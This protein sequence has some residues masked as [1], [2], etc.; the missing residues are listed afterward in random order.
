MSSLASI[1]DEAFCQHIASGMTHAEA[2]RQVSGRKSKNTDVNAAQW[3]KHP[4]VQ[5][6]IRELKAQN[7]TKSQLTRE[8]AMEWLTAVVK[9]P[10][11]QINMDHP[12]A[13]SYKVDTDGNLDVRMPDKIGAIQILCKMCGW[14]EPDRVKFSVD[15]SLS[16]YLLELRAQPI[17]GTVL[18]FGHQLLDLENG[19]N[20]EANGEEIRRRGAQ[21]VK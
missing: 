4:G 6:R 3:M 11:G 21:G 15:D 17:G 8:E 14:F 2:Y 5:E 1:R 16:A 20:G 18:P 13:Q 19:E 12:L 9:T 10:A 7:D